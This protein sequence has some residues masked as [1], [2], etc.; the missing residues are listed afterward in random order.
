MVQG[1]G[2]QYSLTDSILNPI[3][4]KIT[5]AGSG[6]AFGS[7]GRFQTCIVVEHENGRW[8]LDCGASSIVALK[9]LGISPS[10]IDTVLITHLHGD[11]FGGIPFLILDGQFSKR[12]TPLLLVGPP[13]LRDRVRSA[14]EALFPASS[15]TRQKFDIEFREIP[16]ETRVTVKSATVTATPM[17]HFSG[18]PPYGLRVELDDRVIAYSGDTEWTEGLLKLCENADLFICEA[19]FLEKKIKYHLDYSTILA[20]RGELKCKRIILTHMNEEMISRS[21]ELEIECAEDGLALTL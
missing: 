4:M 21:K 20:H 5:F 2:R 12:E 1:S 3:R 13:G 17:I 7:G 6:D 8:L 16:A 14:M 18:A 9:K 19:Y 11:H 10:T 15:R